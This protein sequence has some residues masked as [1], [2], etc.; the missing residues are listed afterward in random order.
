MNTLGFCCACLFALISARLL[1]FFRTTSDTP[2]RATGALR[3]CGNEVRSE[4]QSQR[5]G[6]D[7]EHRATAAAH[8]PAGGQGTTNIGLARLRIE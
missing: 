6:I 2:V 3:V 7:S 5:Y 4:Q 1:R 8:R